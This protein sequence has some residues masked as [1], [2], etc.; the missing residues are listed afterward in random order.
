[1]S[2]VYY[3]SIIALN[4]NFIQEYMID[5]QKLYICKPLTTTFLLSTAMSQYVLDTTYE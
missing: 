4:Q 1:M 3:T 2:V 5:K